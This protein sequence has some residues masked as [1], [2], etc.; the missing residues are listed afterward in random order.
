[1]TPFSGEI[2]IR[3]TRGFRGIGVRELWAYR[4]LI[5]LFVWRDFVARYKQTVLGPL[6]Y[7]FQPLITTF[8]FTLVF[9]HV[10]ALST[11]GLPPTLFYL[12]GLLP[13][14]YFAQTFTSTSGTLV[15]NAGLFGKVYFPRLV[16]PIS[17]V[18]SNLVAFAIQFVLFVVMYGLHRASHFDAAYGMRWQALLLPVVLLQ[19]AALSLGVGLWLAALTAKFRDFAVLSTFLVQ[20]WMYVTP[21]IY[22]LAQVPAQWRVWVAVNPM[23]VP[24]E[25]FRYLLLGTGAV[26]GTLI[27]V[28]LAVTTVALVSGVLA[29]QRVEKTFVD[30]I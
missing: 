25:A 14:N 24:V 7:V 17:A 1:M 22:P 15:A 8:I 30:V 6:W 5:L 11:D 27:A 19:V 26:N 12:C 29:F 3:P 16:V 2:A 28:S 10:A 23:A 21:I 4:D 13:W 18:I 20:L 9:S